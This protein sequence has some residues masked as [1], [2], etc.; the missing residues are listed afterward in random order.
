MNSRRTPPASTSGCN[1]GWNPAVDPKALLHQTKGNG[2]GSACGRPWGVP[3]ARLVTVV[4]RNFLATPSRTTD[5]HDARPHHQHQLH[6]P[7]QSPHRLVPQW[8]AVSAPTGPLRPSLLFWNSSLDHLASCRACGTQPRVLPKPVLPAQPLAIAALPVQLVCA[9]HRRGPGKGHSKVRDHPSRR[10][11]DTKNSFVI[12]VASLRAKVP[13][14]Q[15]APHHL[16]WTGETITFK[17][18]SYLQIGEPA[19]RHG[20]GRRQTVGGT[21]EQ[22]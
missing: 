3:R 22:P 12:E 16:R 7:K 8:K 11:E 5:A 14:V 13:P 18:A 17:S 10:A 4:P 1:N 20:H 21:P 19:I 9:L 15:P 6:P 2:P